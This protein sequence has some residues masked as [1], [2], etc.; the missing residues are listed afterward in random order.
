MNRVT[1]IVIA[2]QCST[3]MAACCTV[4]A[5]LIDNGTILNANW[6]F[7]V[8]VLLTVATIFMLVP[9][10]VSH[11]TERTHDD[12]FEFT[13]NEDGWLSPFKEN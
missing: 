12:T 10:I 5:I 8:Y 11:K 7:A 6:Q 1:D 9:H 4:L 3:V 13:I 2:T